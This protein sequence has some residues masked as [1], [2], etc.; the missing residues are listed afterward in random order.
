MK[1]EKKKNHHHNTGNKYNNGK[2]GRNH[3]QHAHKSTPEQS[4]T[5]S[6]ETEVYRASDQIECPIASS[7]TSHKSKKSTMCT[8]VSKTILHVLLCADLL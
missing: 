4:I 3:A 5:A 1:N 8:K 7:S 6:A 2:H